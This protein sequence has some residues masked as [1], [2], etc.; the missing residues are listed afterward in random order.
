MNSNPSIVPS[1]PR[2]L[3]WIGL[4]AALVFPTTSLFA[5]RMHVSESF[6]GSGLEGLIGEPPDTSTW[7]HPA[8]PDGN[9]FPRSTAPLVD[10][11][12]AANKAHLGK[13]L[14]WDEQVGTDNTMACGT[15]HD[16]GAG[17]ADGRGS[18]FQEASGTF[19]SA[20]IIAQAIDPVTG[21]LDYT[22][23]AGLPVTID[24]GVTPIIAP[25]MIGAYI[26]NQ[27]F[28]DM[29][30]GPTFDFEGGGTI[31][32]FGDWAALEQL[33]TGPPL[34]PIEM[35]HDALTW[36]SNFLQ[37]KIG[38]SF[39]LALCDP[40]PAKMSID[41]QKAV[42]L[43]IVYEKWFENVFASDPDPT[44]AAGSGVT[45]ERFAAAL[46]HYM[47]TLIPDQAPIDLGT[48]TPDQQAGFLRVQSGGCFG[49][50]SVG[51]SVALTTPAGGF[52]DPFDAPLTN[53]NFRDVRGILVKT[54][55]LRNVGLK[56]RFF[57]DGL[58]DNMP[59]LLD[60]Y[61]VRFGFSLT[62]LEAAQVTD[63]L[64]N[65]LTDPRVALRL[66]PFD[67]PELASERPEHIFE[68]NEFGAAVSGFTTPEII[69]NSP[70]YDAPPGISEAFKVGVANC[71]PGATAR[72]GILIPPSTSMIFMPAETVNA[73]GFATSHIKLPLPGLSTVGPQTFSARWFVDDA[74]AP[75]GTAQSNS[76]RWT[77]F[78]F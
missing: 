41:F 42:G 1:S 32:N 4:V 13:A 17:G 64:V 63:F 7:P 16:T 5:Q 47:R 26:F 69:A 58:I 28:W 55:S 2:P 37:K 62:P 31:P 49:C 46:A 25:P 33:A 29:R 35:G 67:K 61:D 78:N 21:R 10:R 19:A 8:A 9:P 30:A 75:S 12:R 27:L 45:R 56:R 34:S 52:V 15:C 23:G 60:F 54:P 36:S 74:G 59:D 65:A 24:R 3:R 39:P 20:G 44:L 14:F 18:L 50:H 6:P 43:G 73:S 77:T 40:D 71:R 51:G 48:M 72:L 11:R 66:P 22:F 70:A 76:A 53:G 68:G 57:T 38:N